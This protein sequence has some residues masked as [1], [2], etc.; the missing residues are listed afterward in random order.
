MAASKVAAV[1]HLG[2]LPRA[3]MLLVEATAVRVVAK[4]ATAARSSS[5]AAAVVATKSLP[6]SEACSLQCLN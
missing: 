6:S 5:K 3:A 4:V 2:V 1:A